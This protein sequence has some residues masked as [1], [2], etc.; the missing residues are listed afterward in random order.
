[1]APPQKI[2]EPPGKAPAPKLP[3][4]TKPKEPVMPAPSTPTP[5][6]SPTAPETGEKVPQELGPVKPSAPKDQAIYRVDK[7]G[8]RLQNASSLLERLKS[9]DNDA[10]FDIPFVSRNRFYGT[11]DMIEMI[12]YLAQILKSILPEAKLFV[13]DIA[14]KNGGALFKRDP[15]TGTFILSHAGHR[16]GL[17]ADISYIPQPPKTKP[18]FSVRGKKTSDIRNMIH[19]KVQLAL[20]KQAVTAGNVELFFVYPRVKEALCLE[21][22]NEGALE[23]GHE[24]PI[25]ME[26]LRRTLPDYNGH[27]D[28]PDIWGHADHFHLRL[29]CDKNVHPH[30]ENPNSLVTASI[31]CFIKRK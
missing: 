29:R 28:Q 7:T 17:D 1:V 2:P 31:G 22:L 16:N 3:A 24:D 21:A 10:P 30:C 13:S 26:P 12:D 15:K 25:T 4:P 14:Q 27:P 9:Y 23:E 19:M 11:S 6:T 18:F 20:F 5:P 8:G